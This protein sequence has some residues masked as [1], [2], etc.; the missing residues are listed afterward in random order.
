[1]KENQKKVF[2][3]L[4]NIEEFNPPFVTFRVVCSKGTYV[5]ALCHDIGEE[6]GMG[7]HIVELERTRVGKFTVENSI[8]SERLKKI[9]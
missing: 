1:M 4:F 9:I 2:I 6:L 8:D 5:R 3:H 7:A